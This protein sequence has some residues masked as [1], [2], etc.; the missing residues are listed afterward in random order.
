[1]E[2]APTFIYA[3]PSYDY[4]STRIGFIR[5][6]LG[7]ISPGNEIIDR[8]M[9]EAQSWPSH[10]SYV[11]IGVDWVTYLPL[12]Y[13]EARGEIEA[14]AKWELEHLDQNLQT[15]INALR[16]AAGLA[17]NPSPIDQIKVSI[18][19]LQ[20]LLKEQSERLEQA[21]QQLASLPQQNYLARTKENVVKDILKGDGENLSEVMDNEMAGLTLTHNVASLNA[22]IQ[23]LNARLGN[24]EAAKTLTFDSTL[25]DVMRANQINT[26][27]RV[28]AFVAQAGHESLN[29]T[30][31]TENLNYSAAA[32]MNSWP[33]RFTP[34]QAQQVAYQPQQIAE[35]AYGG[36]MGNDQPGDGFKYRGRGYF[37]IS[38][39]AMYQSVGQALGLDLINHPELLEQQPHAGN[40]AGLYWSNN[41]FNAKADAGNF[42]GI[43]QVINGGQNGAADRTSRYNAVLNALNAV[44]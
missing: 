40:S 39:K 20:Q 32:I 27:E 34:A 3:N 13:L 9:A 12:Q 25:E 43:T 33:N 11:D 19:I 4:G 35:I 2:I 17:A 16:S 18:P 8:T 21:K 29:L 15:D 41:N 44:K 37:Q 5:V 42:V 22:S 36:R 30:R 24:F 7:R 28:A 31:V 14:N 26:K 38:G 10:D 1:M 23:N 6:N